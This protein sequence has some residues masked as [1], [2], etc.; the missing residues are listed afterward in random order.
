M[1]ICRFKNFREVFDGYR[2]KMSREGDTL[3]LTIVNINPDDSGEIECRAYNK[4]GTASIR[5]RLQMQGKY[6]NKG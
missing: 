2:H 3:A 5:A 4:A 6:E 1:L